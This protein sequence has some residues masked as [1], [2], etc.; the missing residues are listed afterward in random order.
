M[1]A[2][3][4][5]TRNPRPQASKALNPGFWPGFRALEAWGFGFRILLQIQGVWV[6]GLR[7]WGFRVLGFELWGFEVWVLGFRGV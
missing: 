5:E 2:R 7:L 4:P 1:R 6:C 3:K